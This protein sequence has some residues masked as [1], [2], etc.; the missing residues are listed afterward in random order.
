MIITLETI[1]SVENAILVDIREEYER[2]N[3]NLESAL[4][5][6]ME[7]LVEQIENFSDSNNY[8]LFCQS[9]T[10]STNLVKLLKAKGH[11]NFYSL[12]GGAS[13]LSEKNYK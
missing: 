6:P 9:G 8:I 11:S 5:A 10:R 7:T 3:Y 13:L 4:N 1:D 12:E 2:E